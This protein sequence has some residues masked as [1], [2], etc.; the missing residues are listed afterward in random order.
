[1]GG[2]CWPGGGG[3]ATRWAFAH[4]CALAKKGQQVRA[5]GKGGGG[6]GGG[7]LCLV[8][9]Q[10]GESQCNEGAGKKVWRACEVRHGWPQQYPQRVA[11]N[12]VVGWLCCSWAHHT[13]RS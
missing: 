3:V 9:P 5:R 11:I 8:L 10:K 12:S 4:A 2:A 13:P 1:M 6:G 7:R